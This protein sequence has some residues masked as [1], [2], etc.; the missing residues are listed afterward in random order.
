MN[1]L[2]LLIYA[3]DGRGLGHASRSVAI[4]LAVRRLFP[5]L[6]VLFLSGAKQSADLIGEGELDWIKLPAYQTRVVGGVSKGCDGESNFSDRELGDIRSAMIR[7]LVV[8]LNPRCVL[9]DHMPQGQTSRIDAGLGGLRFQGQYTVDS[10]DAGCHRR[11]GRGVV[12]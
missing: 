5:E 9:S 8:R 1:R 3:H 4:G 2:D 7:D 12:G 11:C 6:K 10:W